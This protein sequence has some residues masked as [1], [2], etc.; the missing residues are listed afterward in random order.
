MCR[1]RDEELQLSLEGMDLDRRAK[2]QGVMKGRVGALGALNRSQ[3]ALYGK[4]EEK[5][6]TAAL[7]HIPF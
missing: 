3:P 4:F 7:M 2:L 5:V 1:S 6:F